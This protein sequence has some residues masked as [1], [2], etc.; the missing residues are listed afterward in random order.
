MTP[1][2]PSDA[3]PTRPAGKK[4][5]FIYK[6]LAA[7]SLLMIVAFGAL[8]GLSYS[9][10]SRSLLSQIDRQTQEAG[11]LAVDGIEK[12]L[13][14]RQ[15]LLQNLADDIEGAGEDWPRLLPA[16]SLT[17][18]FSTVY[19]GDR[20]GKIRLEPS[21]EL[22]AGYD[23]RTRPWYQGAAV[24]QHTVLTP[25]YADAATGKL[26]LTLARAVRKDQAVL[27][28]AGADLYLD[29]IVELLR[30]LDLGGNGYAF[31]IAADGTVLVHP[32]K[33][34]IMKK[35]D[36]V[37]LDTGSAGLAL[38]DGAS[39]TSFFPIRGLPSVEWHVGISLDRA[40]V[41]APL[42]Q[43]RHL[44]IAVVLAALAVVVAVLGFVVYRLVARPIVGMTAA[45]RALAGGDLER[46][47]PARDRS[48]EI[49]EMAQALLV[50]RSS[51]LETERLRSEQK[52][53]ERRAAEERRAAMVALADNFEAHVGGIVE[54]V[55]ASA[56]EM[57]STAGSLTTTAQE[58]TQQSTAVAAAAEQA[59]A[60]V[61]TVASAAE[62]L[63]GSIEEI[64]RQVS[65]STLIAGKAV[66][67]AERTN[68][69]VQG[70]AEAAQKIG[71]VVSLINDIANQTNL[72]ALNA[73]IEAARAGDAGKGFAVVASEVK[74][75]ATQTAKATEEITG[76]ISGIQQ[77]TQ[78]AVAAIRSI[79]QTIGSLNEIATA[80]AGAV[81]EQG[82]A[83]Q[84]IARNVQQA[85]SGTQQV[86][87]NVSGLNE[88]AGATDAA[89]GQML[90]AS[91]ELARQGEYLRGEVDRFL[92]AVRAA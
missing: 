86:S 65:Q 58:T 30:S 8:G 45:M 33:A 22:P 70:L 23:P 24:A 61:Q 75:L 81:E 54:A 66:A 49:G 13:G 20:D 69:E 56:T 10:A 29:T 48:D 78:H 1:N 11:R 57:Q 76:Q 43:F 88:A 32:D 92:Q 14:G 62:E 44:L 19:Y 38:E 21:V 74:N 16:K 55:S 91:G 79:G 18:T 40:R 46:A 60:N 64:G 27:G 39:M 84:E 47:V 9:I 73:T 2:T 52:E 25:P 26:T 7:T 3:A 82:A 85:A 41:M 34:R 28:V 80:I 15:A 87:A 37:R 51:M 53:M 50:F 83:T 42:D 67:E 36:G 68:S 31:L 90:G 35:L 5:K 89:A 72:L 71:E 6:I 63:S 77:A 17:D 12:W 59:S 4:T